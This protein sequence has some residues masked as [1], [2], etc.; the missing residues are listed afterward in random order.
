MWKLAHSRCE[1]IASNV[2]SELLPAGEELKQPLYIR[3]EPSVLLQH[4]ILAVLHANLDD[5]EEALAESTVMGF[6]YVYV[7]P[8][9]FRERIGLI[10]N[11]LLFEPGHLWMTKNAI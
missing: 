1:I 4:S 8:S 9:T 6:V 10:A 11:T 2:G 5:T 3:T 7:S